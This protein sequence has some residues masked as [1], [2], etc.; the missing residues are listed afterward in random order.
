V[1]FSLAGFFVFTT[2]Q[3]GS[4]YA[5]LDA[6][7]YRDQYQSL[8]ESRARIESIRQGHAVQFWYDDKDRA[9][10]DAVAL[11]STYLWSSSL[12]GRSFATPPCD[13]EV[14]PSTII[15]VISAN[16]TH[17]TDFAVSA[18]TACW[19]EKG[20]RAV[21]VETRVVDRDLYTYTMPILR[22]EVVPGMWLPLA[23]A[24]SDQP[25]AFPLQNWTVER[26]DDS[27]AALGAVPDG[28]LVRT[29]ARP[30]SLA[31]LYPVIKAPAAGRY[32]FAIRYWPGAGRFGFG[33]YTHG[34]AE[35]LAYVTQGN[36]AG[37]DY[38]MALWVNL[39]E[40]QEFQLG[41]TNNNSQA[42]PASFLM[43]AVTAVRM[44][45]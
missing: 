10:P 24:G 19:S 44:A 2:L 41:L 30:A 45:R 42:L 22:V 16:R 6:H 35:P 29:H 38:E 36:W 27:T 12:L 34:R 43:K 15:A 14:P 20:L 39:A 9:M 28:V 37:N 25:Y 17:G 11:S 4:S 40:G 18:L 32:R 3:V 5:N 26:G 8:M 7:A 1:S 13:V 31:A 23:P 33:A 21:P